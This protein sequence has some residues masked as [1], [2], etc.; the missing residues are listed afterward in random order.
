MLQQGWANS[1]PPQR[2]K[3][4]LKHSENIFISE[5]SSNLYHYK[6]LFTR[7]PRFLTTDG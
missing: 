3:W 2:F 7:W 4:P 6:D 1:G 5:I